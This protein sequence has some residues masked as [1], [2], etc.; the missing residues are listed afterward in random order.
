MPH[1]RRIV[2]PGCVLHIVNRGNDKKII[3]PEPLDYASFLVLLREARERFGVRLLAYS[4]MPNHFHLTVHV[5][6]LE[7]IS[8]YMH[9]VQ[10]E[11]ACDLRSCYRSKGHGH[12]FQ[13]RYWSKLVEGDG[14][15]IAVM[16][17]VEA[18]ALRAGLVNRAEDWEWGSLWDRVTGERDLL[19][20]SNLWL[21]DDWLTIVNTPLQRVELEK[22]RRP[23]GRG[24]PL[25]KAIYETRKNVAGSFI[26]GG[27]AAP[28]RSHDR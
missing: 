9:F 14:Q 3:F 19:E 10:R 21:P 2:P 28:C 4:L 18:N 13:R 11:H 16:R 26:M 20:A 1:R 27:A 8:S 7:A 15:L 24:R 6:D 12:I 5:D 23:I 25:K 22:I 17:Y